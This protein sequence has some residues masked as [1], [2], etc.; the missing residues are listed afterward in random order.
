MTITLPVT[1]VQFD[2]TEA[3]KEIYQLFL[4]GMTL[5]RA[6]IDSITGFDQQRT[7]RAL[8]GLME[9]GLVAKSGSTRSSKYKKA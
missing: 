4:N 8:K 1:D 3:E 7:L 9:K 6:Q 5:T 2:F